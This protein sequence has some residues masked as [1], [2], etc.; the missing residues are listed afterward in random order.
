MKLIAR[1][2][3]ENEVELKEIE[4]LEKDAKLL[5]VKLN[6]MLRPADLE[7]VEKSLTEKIGI[8]VIALNRD[9]D[10]IYSL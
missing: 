6:T 7:N 4:G 5:I 1:F 2:E 3:D 10:K 9:I 8:K